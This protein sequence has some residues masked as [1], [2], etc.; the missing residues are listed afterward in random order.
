MEVHIDLHEIDGIRRWYGRQ[1]HMVRTACGRMLNEFAFGTRLRAIRKIDDLMTVRN[2]K[3][4][5][6]RIRVTKAN[7]GAAVA[8]QASWTGSVAGPRFTGWTEQ[9]KGTPSKRNRFSTLAGRGGSEQKQMRHAIRL[10]P[11]HEVVTAD[12]P[13][14]QPKGGKTSGFVAMLMRKK[15]TR[16]VRIKG[17]FYKRNRKRLQLVQEMKPRQPKRKRWL[18]QARAEY[19]RRTD[20]QALWRRIVTPLMRK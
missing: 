8:A 20:I 18:R 11:K 12:H 3:F 15:E 2:P 7:I 10:K 9:E 5:A 17:S 14:Y 6:S 4:V 1:P 13:D 16:M 19:F